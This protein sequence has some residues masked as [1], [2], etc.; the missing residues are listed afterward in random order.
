L[1]SDAKDTLDRVVLSSLSFVDKKYIIQRELSTVTQQY[2][3]NTQEVENIQRDIAQ[4]GYLPQDVANIFQE[5]NM[6]VSLQRGL[7][8]LEAIKFTTA[9]KV[10]SYLD[11]F[12]VGLADY[13][14]V[15]PEYVRDQ[16]QK[17]SS[18]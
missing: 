6:Q 5:S 14:S 1:S 16:M 11:T 18:R 7:V 9:I 10:F 12:V 3:K 4:Y 15:S 8:A 13:L 2:N 17:M